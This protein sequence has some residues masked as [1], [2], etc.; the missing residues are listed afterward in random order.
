[1]Y[2]L[3][4]FP[5]DASLQE[6]YPVVIGQIREEVMFIP[7][8]TPEA[9]EQ[10]ETQHMVLGLFSSCLHMIGQASG[11]YFEV[12]AALNLRGHKLGL[13]RIGRNIDGNSI[14]PTSEVNS[15]VLLIN[16]NGTGTPLS[17]P[18]SGGLTEMSGTM[19]DPIDPAFQI[20]YRFLGRQPLRDPTEVFFAALDALAEAAPHNSETRVQR[21]AGRDPR[22]I[23][24]ARL[25]ISTVARPA[26]QVRVLTYGYASRT[27]ELIIRLMKLSTVFRNIEFQLRYRGEQ[28]GEGRIEKPRAGSEVDTDTEA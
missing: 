10:M 4:L 18:I 11:P 27:I 16:A 20:N 3:T 15:T 13:V 24:N 17:S 8:I 12:T 19:A 26:P 25:A 5:W 2:T 23:N 21:L 9:D 7:T 6:L 28:F 1:M 14:A 22:S